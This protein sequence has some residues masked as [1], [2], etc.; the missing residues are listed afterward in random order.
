MG[1]KK[2]KS[3]ELSDKKIQFTVEKLSYKAIRY[4]PTAMSVDVMEY[5]DKGNKVGVRN[6]PFAHVPKD[7]KKLIKPN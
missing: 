4:Y 1:K 2:K 6:I 7:I 3:V 5:D